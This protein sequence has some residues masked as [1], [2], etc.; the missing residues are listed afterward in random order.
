MS[1]PAF[2]N[3]RSKVRRRRSHHALKA[4]QYT[5]CK[6]CGTVIMPHKACPKCGNYKGRVVKGEDK[7]VEKIIEKK[8][9]KK[10]S[11]KAKNEKKSSEK[12]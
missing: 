9:A 3:S 2:K 7:A 1:V 12:K 10:P 5:T 11:V 4:V 8:T 6:K